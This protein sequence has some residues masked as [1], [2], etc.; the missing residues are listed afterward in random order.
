MVARAVVKTESLYLKHLWPFCQELFKTNSA[1]SSLQSWDGSRKRTLHFAKS[2]YLSA[3]IE[4][5]IQIFSSSAASIQI[6][7]RFEFW[8]LQLFWSPFFPTALFLMQHYPR[9]RISTL[10][11]KF[12]LKNQVLSKTGQSSWYAGHGYLKSISVPALVD[13]LE[14]VFCLCTGDSKAWPFVRNWKHFL[15]G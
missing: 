10:G 3:G 1:E 2:N 7:K 15:F 8:R 9:L 6:W 13:T 11:L 12:Q 5:N 14:K 4:S